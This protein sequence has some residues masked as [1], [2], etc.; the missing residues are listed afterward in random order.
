MKQ[1]LRRTLRYYPRRGQGSAFSIFGRID[2]RLG[3]R[4]SAQ[5]SVQ[6]GAL[7]GGQAA[8]QRCSS[9]GAGG[10]SGSGRTIGEAGT[11]VRERSIEHAIRLEATSGRAGQGGQSA[12]ARDW[13]RKGSLLV[14]AG[15]AEVSQTSA[16][17]GRA[18]QEKR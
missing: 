16:G 17:K 9:E 14:Q 6:A 5:V 12:D 3:K 13:M 1:V 11:Q 10:R 2:T 4:I 18:R 15:L 7:L 8:E